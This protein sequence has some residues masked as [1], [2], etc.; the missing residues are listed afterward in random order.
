MDFGRATP[1]WT[2]NIP[3]G[4]LLFLC[5]RACVCVCV[6]VSVCV[7]V[8]VYVCVCVSVWRENKIR[9]NTYFQVQSFSCLQ[10]EV[11]QLIWLISTVTISF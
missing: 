4:H 9:Y 3:T 1:M 8:C 5:V 11:K 7:C 10:F 2:L 6:C